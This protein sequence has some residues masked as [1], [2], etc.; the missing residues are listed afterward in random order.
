MVVTFAINST[1]L[2]S[3]VGKKPLR[4]PIRKYLYRRQQI[5]CLDPSRS[6]L[7]PLTWYDGRH[8]L[9]PPRCMKHSLPPCVLVTDRSAFQLDTF[10]LQLLRVGL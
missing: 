10:W 7:A 2:F 4:L 9:T 6:P 1:T 3:S 8:P 5:Q